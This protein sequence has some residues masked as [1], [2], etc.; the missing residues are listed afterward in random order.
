MMRRLIFLLVI[1]AL[2]RVVPA[3]EFVVNQ[4]DAKASDTN[5]ATPGKPLKTISAAATKVQAGDKVVIHAGQYRETV[6]ISASGTTDAPITFEA[7]PGET[8]VIKGSEII[9]HWTRDTGEI[10]K[11]A[12]PIPPTKRSPNS[13]DSTFWRTNNVR[14]V[15]IKDGEQLDAQ[16]LRRVSAKD[17][18]QPGAFF[19]DLPGN[20][21]FVWLPGSA[22]PNNTEMEVA[23]R[24]AWL[25]VFGNNITIRGLQM[26]H[27]STLGIVNWPACVLNGNN[28][29][30]E[31]CSISWSDFVGVSLGGNNDKLLRCT[32]ACHG[33]TGIGGA[34]EGHL[35]EGCR[36][37]Y[38]NIDRYYFNWHCGGAKL[39]P[40]F[41]HGRI[42]HNEFA[43]NIGPGL[44]LDGGCNDNLIEGNLCHDNEGPGI[45]VEISA[46]NRVFNNISYAN[47]N[48]LQSDYL[49]AGRGTRW[50]RPLSTA[51][52]RR[53]MAGSTVVSCW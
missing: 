2:P 27:S 22:N 30:L 6:I 25:Y 10:W 20:L 46:R 53:R 29:T 36:I 28:V 16:H 49:S 7:A 23:L 18:L 51:T 44:W 14:M 39:I 31:S 11:A 17:Q 26:R 52:P 45:V 32:I 8:V 43:Y 34:G 37:V 47:R 15:I 24:G 50:A 19:C 33:S 12:L 21:L 4:K 1:A 9:K 3:R 13:N 48:P 40:N 35:I 41:T 38:N 5:E 42:S